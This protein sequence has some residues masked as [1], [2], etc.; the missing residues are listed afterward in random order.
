MSSYRART[1]FDPNAYE[2]AGP[3][4]RPYNRMQW[5][6]VGFVW[7]GLAGYLAWAADRF[8]WIDIGLDRPTAFVALPMIGIAL[9]NSRRQPGTQ[10]GT[11]Q[12][13]RNRRILAVTLAIGAAV[14]GATIAIIVN[15]QGA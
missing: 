4:M 8:G 12:L 6:G 15:T 2:Q 13:R 14:L 3:P 5:I 1:S 9:I 10:A 11:E 7:I